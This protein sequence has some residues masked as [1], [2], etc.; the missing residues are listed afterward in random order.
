MKDDL[1]DT[2][3]E[4]TVRKTT[5]EVICGD[6]LPIM[7]GYKDKQFDLVL[8]DPP[9]G[10]GADKGVGG[11]IS[12]GRKYKGDWD[13][14]PKKEY[15]DEILRVSK[16]AVIFGGNFF[17]DLLPVNGHWI[18]WDKVG[19]IKFDNPYSGAE[20]A[21]TNFDKNTVKKYVVIQAGFI[22]EEKDRHHPTMKPVKLFGSIL[23]DYT[24]DEMTILDP[25]LGS[26]T[27]L[28]AC[29]QLNRNGVGIE[30]S[31]EYCEI[32]RKRLEQQ[33]LL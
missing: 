11:G 10:I 5:Q 2:P 8:C 28:V 17:T 9:Y 21:W 24:T 12:K 33:T 20:L 31:P 19:E 3:S 15:F 22:A 23:A 14:R 32:A 6:C 26:G 16:N 7:R 18:V 4:S 25:F 27:T 29:K 13:V 30:I 1:S